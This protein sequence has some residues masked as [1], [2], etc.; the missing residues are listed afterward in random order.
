[1]HAA[2]LLLALLPQLGPDATVSVAN[3][4]R[5]AREEIARVTLPFAR[6]AQH[7]L[8]ALQI[9]GAPASCV[10]LLR[11]SDGSLAAVQAQFRVQLQPG[12]RRSLTVAAAA[13]AP[14]PAAATEWL[15]PAELPLRSE[16]V[17][18]FAQRYETTLEPAE[19]VHAS[20]LV[21]VQRYRGVHRTP[22]GRELF[23]LVGYLT[24]FA[25][26][27]RAE[28]V[29][30]LD[31][32]ASPHGPRPALGPLRFTSW[33]LASTTEALRLV[34][35]FRRENLLKPPAPL[36]QAGWQQFLLGPSS[37]LYLGDA[38]GKAFRFELFLDGPEATAAQRTSALAAAEAPLRPLPALAWVRR[39]RAFGAHGG[40][41][42]LRSDHDDLSGQ[43]LRTWQQALQLGPFSGFGEPE[44]TAAQGTPRNGDSALHNVLRFESGDLFDIAELMATQQSLRPS[45]GRAQ[46]L[47]AD[48]APFR[49]GLTPRSCERPHGFTALDYEHF[50]VDLLYDYYWL[51]GDPLAHDELV[52]TARGLRQVLET[53]PF[54]T[55]RGEGWCLQAGVLLARATADPALTGFL[56]THALAL[57]GQ[58]GRVPQGIALAQPGHALGLGEQEP[59]DAPWQM[60]ALVRGLAALH[61][62][63]AAPEFAAAAVQ[64]A[65]VMAGPGWLAGVGPKYLVSA[66]DPGR[67][68]MPVA[69]GPLTGTGLMQLG[70]F[71]LAE[72][73]S[74]DP[75]SRARFARRAQELAAVQGPDEHGVFAASPWTQI[76]HDRR[77]GS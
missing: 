63:T 14:A 74:S 35:R 69:Y 37:Q 19:I 26:E 42:P 24:T 70:A 50:S 39:T 44:D 20:A 22:A 71:V 28:L 68:T 59:F 54:R 76:W 3:R 30:L 53:V 9:G 32:G 18:P 64:V 41:G 73:L 7:A 17:D 4:T 25:G 11:W 48:T 72:E 65:D 31:N 8:P 6:G 75:D 21:R 1:M 27:R 60:A 2:P 10:P 34:P 55:S 58:L 56:R 29:L 33:A 36:P 61:A 38:T 23:A 57:L 51:T 49:A 62:E 40:P 52:R 67:Y 47:P 15:F 13:A 12:E 46:V 5:F 77:G 16:V 66:R 43:Q 45:P